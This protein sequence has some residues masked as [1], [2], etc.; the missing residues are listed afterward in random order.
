MISINRKDKETTAILISSGINTY[1]ELT[2]H[3]VNVYDAASDQTRLIY[4]LHGEIKFDDDT[5]FTLTEYGEDLLY[6]LE[7]NRLHSKLTVITVIAS[8]IAAI[9]SLI[10][11]IPH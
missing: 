3:G 2:D 6:T 4:P 7:Q 9:C 8:I 11:I 10:S 5:V 1:K